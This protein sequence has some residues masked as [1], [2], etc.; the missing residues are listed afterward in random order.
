[1]KMQ[2]SPITAT[3]IAISRPS[4]SAPPQRQ[5]ATVDKSVEEFVQMASTEHPELAEELHK[6]LKDMKLASDDLTRIMAENTGN[7]WNF[8]IFPGE[9]KYSYIVS[10]GWQKILEMFKRMLE[11][12]Q[13]PRA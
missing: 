9:S 11:D 7:V 1:M 3:N 4:Y 12:L 2:L 5:G 13:S 6:V 8:T 10:A